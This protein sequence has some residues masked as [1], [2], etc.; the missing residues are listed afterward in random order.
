MKVVAW[1]HTEGVVIFNK[2]HVLELAYQDVRGV[3]RLFFIASPM[4]YRMAMKCN[5][6]LH[7]SLEVIMCQTSTFKN[8]PVYTLAEV[9]CFLLDKYKMFAREEDC[10]FG[11]KG[12]NFQYDTLKKLNIP[13]INLEMFNVPSVATLM[14]T[15]RKYC[16]YH[17]DK[18]KKCAAH[19]LNLLILFF[20]N[21]FS[22]SNSTFF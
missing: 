2:Y 15:S 1:I 11:Y 20:N 3:K 12:K 13:A 21:S 14:K 4:S 19:I 18:Q 8:R 16:P 9:E 5:P 22:R 10:V 6:Y 7:K 17:V